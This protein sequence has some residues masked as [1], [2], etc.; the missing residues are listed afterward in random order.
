MIS[1]NVPKGRPSILMAGLNCLFKVCNGNF[2]FARRLL[3]FCRNART[4]DHGLEMK[5][6]LSLRHSDNTNDRATGAK[7]PDLHT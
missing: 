7:G 3:S 2:M 6:E 5:Q 1:V 4:H